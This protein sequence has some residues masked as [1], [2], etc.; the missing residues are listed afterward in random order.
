MN[1]RDCAT[2]SGA[3]SS[4]VSGIAGSGILRVCGRPRSW[5][6]WVGARVFSGLSKDFRKVVMMSCW[7]LDE[8]FEKTYLKIETVQ[9]IVSFIAYLLK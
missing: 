7:R 8:R 6:G 1:K 5:L 4:R 9:W 2:C 3:R